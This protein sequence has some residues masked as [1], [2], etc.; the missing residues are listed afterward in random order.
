MEKYPIS[1]EELKWVDKQLNRFERL[2]SFAPKE[3]QTESVVLGLYMIYLIILAVISGALLSFGNK[4]VIQ[5]IT[6]F[7]IIPLTPII[8]VL[9]LIFLNKIHKRD[10]RKHRLTGNAISKSEEIQKSETSLLSH[11]EFKITMDNDAFG[12][13]K[14]QLP[15]V[16]FYIHNHH[17]NKTIDAYVCLKVL[18]GGNIIRDFA[19]RKNDFYN[20]K[21]SFNLPPYS[22]PFR[23]VFEVPNEAKDSQ[24][25]LSVIVEV[26]L[27][28][29][30]NK[31]G[32]KFPP[33]EFVYVRAGN[34]WFPEPGTKPV[35]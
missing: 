27:S 26:K 16:R 24:E 25:E 21:N 8:L 32:E 18:L 1:S 31:K 2:I 4:D 30:K 3:Y 34:Y 7:S 15:K 6:I 5:T 17:P 23:G 9:F 12:I 13:S 19:E 28:D 11:V 14:A 29:N 10:K 22:H 20:G 35:S 33:R